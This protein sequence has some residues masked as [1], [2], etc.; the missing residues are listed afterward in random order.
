MW[1]AIPVA[2]VLATR[3]AVS[4]AWQAGVAGAKTASTSI[5]QGNAATLGPTGIARAAGVAWSASVSAE[6]AGGYPRHPDGGHGARW[7]HP[8]HQAR[9]DQRQGALQ[10]RYARG[11]T[12][13]TSADNGCPL[14][15]PAV[16]AARTR[17][18]QVN[19]SFTLVGD[20]CG[21]ARP[22]R[23]LGRAQG[24]VDLSCREFGFHANGMMLSPAGWR[25]VVVGARHRSRRLACTATVSGCSQHKANRDERLVV[26]RI[27][28][29][30]LV[31]NVTRTIRYRD[32][33]ARARALPRRL[34][35][36]RPGHRR[37]RRNLRR[38][39]RTRLRR[40][41]DRSQKRQSPSHHRNL[42]ATHIQALCEAAGV[43]VV[44]D[45]RSWRLA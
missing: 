35:H 2:K 11:H 33:A 43:F 37:L 23:R 38:S 25:F 41:P 45:D 40:A 36:V 22:G 7:A 31:M 29:G 13:P 8:G 9:R 16:Q 20:G 5:T 14:G 28:L 44:V 34:R 6:R 30:E 21:K 3:H 12:R 17:A 10:R 42:S 26:A 4:T 15:S 39:E 1:G 19:P 27:G 24:S 32:S 18:F